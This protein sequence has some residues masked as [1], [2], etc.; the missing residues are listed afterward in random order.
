MTQMV[1]VLYEEGTTRLQDES[2]NPPKG[3]GYKPSK[4]DGGDEDKPPKGNEGNGEK[5]P[6]TTTFSS[7]PSSPPPSPLP[8]STSTP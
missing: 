8:S 5:P 1:K 6:L 2:S 7:F 4:G 3:D